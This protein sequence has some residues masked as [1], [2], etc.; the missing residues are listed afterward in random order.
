MHVSCIDN[1]KNFKISRLFYCLLFQ[2][3]MREYRIH[4]ISY[5]DLLFTSSRFVLQNGYT[6][7]TEEWQLLSML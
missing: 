5:T 2:S 3:C 6:I 4:A 7:G 1:V